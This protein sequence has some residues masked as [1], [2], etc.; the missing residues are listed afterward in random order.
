MQKDTNIVK[1]HSHE[2]GGA[3][4]RAEYA[5][6]TFCKWVRFKVSPNT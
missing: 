2:A 3:N 5:R 1:M 6:T 4:F